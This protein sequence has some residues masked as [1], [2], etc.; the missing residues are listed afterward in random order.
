MGF[1]AVAKTNIWFTIS[2]TITIT[3]PPYQSGCL[4]NEIS[5][6][7]TGNTE[8]LPPVKTDHHDTDG[9]DK[10][11]NGT[12]HPPCRRVSFTDVDQ[13]HSVLSLKEY[14][15]LEHKATWI[16]TYEMYQS[17]SHVDQQMSR[18]LNGQPCKNKEMT[19]RGLENLTP[20]GAEQLRE[21]SSAVRRVVM[22]EQHQQ[23]QL[24]FCDPE[25]L[26]A[27]SAS[28]SAMSQQLALDVAKADEQE[29]PPFSASDK[30]KSKGMLHRRKNWWSLSVHKTRQYGGIKEYCSRQL[31]T[32]R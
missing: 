25:A 23:R 15:F 10:P 28:I 31:K 5:K 29:V 18:L 9:N 19:Y 7:E 8:L 26:A 11:S 6:E 4:V 20:S 30:A 16:M 12:G 1:L 32:V 13:V 22:E 17:K 21:R 2:G 3:M 27:S 14:T 24:A